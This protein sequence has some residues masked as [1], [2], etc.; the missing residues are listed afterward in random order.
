MKKKL[1]ICHIESKINRSEKYV[2]SR[3]VRSG[4]IGM[5]TVKK[6]IRISEQLVHFESF[7]LNKFHSNNKWKMY[8]FKDFNYRINDFQQL[9]IRYYMQMEIWKNK[10]K[11]FSRN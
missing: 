5:L 9:L 6:R 10:Y 2:E 1:K 11:E 8:Q 4:F 3:N 7:G